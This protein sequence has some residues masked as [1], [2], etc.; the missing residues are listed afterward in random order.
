MERNSYMNLG[1]DVHLDLKVYN[2]SDCYWHLF[3]YLCSLEEGGIRMW[4]LG[5][6]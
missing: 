1:R 2:L 3:Y 5:E 6:E 4:G